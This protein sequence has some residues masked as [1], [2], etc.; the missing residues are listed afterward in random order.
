[1]RSPLPMPA[2]ECMTARNNLRHRVQELL[3][4]AVVWDN[5]GCMPLR[6]DATFLPQLER[7]RQSGVTVASLNVGFADISWVDHMRVLD[8]MRQ[9][10][11][12]RP[13]NF[14]FVLQGRRKARH[15]FRRRGHVSGSERCESGAGIL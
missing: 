7:Y 4:S 1:M 8:F 10:I 11:S 9:L 2:D 14:T 3:R 5:H 15:H 6:A 12:Q 13:E